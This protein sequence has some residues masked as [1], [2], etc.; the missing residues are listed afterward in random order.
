M[1]LSLIVCAYAMSRELPRTIYTL[2]RNYQRGIESLDYEIIVVDNGSPEPVDEAALS[3][4]APNVRVIRTHPAPSSPVKAINAAA[5]TAGGRMLGLFIDGARMA[6]PGLIARAHEAYQ[7]DPS[8]IIGSLAFHLGPDVQMRSVFAGYDQAIEDRLL[9][10]TPW[11]ENGYK[12]FNISALAGSSAEGWFGCIA[13]SNG[14]FLDRDLWQQLGGLEE[15]FVTPGGGL[16]NLDF[17]ERAVTASS[18]RAWMILGEG[19][20]HQVHG[21]VATNGTEATREPMLAEYRQIHGRAFVTPRY[22]PQF[23]GALDD[24]MISRRVGLPATLP[25]KA[26]SINDRAFAVALPPHLLDAV[27]DG[28]L[29]TRYKGLRLAKNPFDL[30]LYLRLLQAL[31]PQTIIEIGTSEGGSA[32]WLR[33]QCHTLGLTTKILSLDLVTPTLSVEGVTFYKA[34]STYPRETFPNEDILSAPHPWLVIEDS[35][36]SYASVSAILDYFDSRLRPNDYIVVEDGVVAD[37]RDPHYRQFDDGPNRAIAEFLAKAGDRYRIDTDYCDFY[38]HNMTYC[39]NGWLVRCEEKPNPSM[40]EG[41]GGENESPS[42]DA[43]TN[44]P[45][46]DPDGTQTAIT[47]NLNTLESRSLFAAIR[48]KI[49]LFLRSNLRGRL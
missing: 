24:E 40:L 4:I 14:V 49:Y 34:D 27:Q 5:K 16:A 39:P 15:R 29:R 32:L 33:D 31:K 21:G 18:G 28:T 19:T 2:S 45:Q 30:A 12:L 43:T 23:V 44:E 22:T 46:K 9:D 6:S 13:E 7:S 38:G 41:G 26:Y 25:R 35:A 11:Q 8:K 1:D 17:W 37:L 10:T 42:L 47:V 36:H 3:G 20:F 48:Q